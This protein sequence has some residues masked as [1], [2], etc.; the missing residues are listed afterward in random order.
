MRKIEFI[1]PVEAMRGNLSGDQKLTYPTQN[2]AAW[3]APEGKRSYATNYRPTYIGAKRSADGKTFFATKRRQAVKMSDAVRLQ[4]AV[5]SASSVV[6]NILMSNLSVVADLEARYRQTAPEGWSF[7]RWIMD[8]IKDALRTKQHFAFMGTSL[9]ALFVKNPYLS[10]DAPAGGT[11]IDSSYP[12]DL[13]VKF[14]MQLADNAI[15]F[16]V[17]KLTGIARN[18]DT[19]DDIIGSTYNVLG[20][21]SSTVDTTDYVTLG[22]LYVVIVDPDDPADVTYVNVDMAANDSENYQLTQTPPS[23]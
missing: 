15:S 13:L 23:A 4:M 11:S 20:L 14:W 9:G 21:T 17:S 2:N 12:K 3:D 19:F 8:T 16:K 18:G 22:I 5:L 6:A 10:T 1:A 7:K